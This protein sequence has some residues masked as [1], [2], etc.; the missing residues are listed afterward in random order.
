[1]N[2]LVDA[3]RIIAALMKKST[4]RDILFDNAFDFVTPDYAISEINDHRRELQEKAKLTD[5]EF[6]IL[7]ALIFECITVLPESVYARFIDECKNEL[8]DVDDI[9]YLAACLASGADGIWSHDPH[10]IKQN[11]VKTF[12][13]I[14]MLEL[15][16]SVKSG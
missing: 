2:I 10:I 12:T 7:V 1:M 8:E 3:N 5:E 4:T 11:K 15:S 14:D 16:R 9:P 6:D 13:N